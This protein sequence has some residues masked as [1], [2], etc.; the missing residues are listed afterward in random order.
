MNLANVH[1]VWATC[2]P[3]NGAS[4]RVLEKAGLCFESKLRNW[5]TRPNLGEAAGDSLV[6]SMH[7]AK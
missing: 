2:H 3:D 1:R 5:E 4:I 7:S 6:Y